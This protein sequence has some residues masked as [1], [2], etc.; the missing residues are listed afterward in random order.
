MVATLSSMQALGR[1]APEFSLPD[2]SI[3]NRLVSLNDFAD[4]PLLV[5]FICNH[6]PYVIHVMS[7]LTQLTNTFLEQ[8]LAAI[9]ISS[10]DTNAYPQDGPEQMKKFANSYGF[11]F[12]YCFDQTQMV[13]KDYGAECTPDFFVYDRQHLLRYR[14]Q[15]DGS[16]PGNSKP[17]TGADLEL[18]VQAILSGQSPDQRQIPSMGCSIKWR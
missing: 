10:N 1:P 4:K 9:A 18:A 8:G 16:R 11:E 5:M 13:A 3:D 2:V 7:A 6:C 15:M 12:P 14:G 17:V